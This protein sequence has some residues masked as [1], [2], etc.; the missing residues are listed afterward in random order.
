MSAHGC[1]FSVTERGADNKATKWVGKCEC[2]DAFVGPTYEAVE[3]GWRQHYYGATETVP[4]PM[5]VKEDRWSA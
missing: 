5:G 1:S 3:D 2:G 4:A